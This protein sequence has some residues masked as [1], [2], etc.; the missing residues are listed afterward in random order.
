[1]VKVVEIYAAIIEIN[2]S[3]QKKD[4]ANLRRQLITLQS[5]LQSEVPSAFTDIDKTLIQLRLNLN[6]YLKQTDLA[7]PEAG[8]L[9]WDEVAQRFAIDLEQTE[10]KQFMTLAKKLR[11]L[12]WI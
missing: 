4:L 10:I 12:Q 11:G 9:F 5:R 6:D 3:F 8:E 1:M 7:T 2:E